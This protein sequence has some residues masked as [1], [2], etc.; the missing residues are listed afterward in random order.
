MRRIVLIGITLALTAVGPNIFPAAQAG[1]S[2]LATLAKY[3]LL[4]SIVALGVIAAANRRR[5]PSLW[6]AI[7]GGGL[8]GAV[9]TVPLEIV[10]LTGFHF[11]YMPGNLP[12]LMGVLLLNRFMLGPNLASDFA[13]W[14]Y[15]FW[16]GA[17]FGIIYSLL[18]GTRRRWLGILYGLAVGIGFMLSPVVTSLGVGRFGLEFSYGFPVTVLLAHAAFGLTLAWL[19]KNWTQQEP[20]VAFSAVARLM[21]RCRN[22]NVTARSPIV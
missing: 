20:S 6:R 18:L 19:A 21:A 7:V 16:N 12:R 5:D 14:T 10:R 8:A 15:H 11:G 13:G 22:T 2:D 17:S 4:P 9:A 1:Y 3:L